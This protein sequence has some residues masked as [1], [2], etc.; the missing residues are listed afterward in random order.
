MSA[1]KRL[2]TTLLAMLLVLQLAAQQGD[3]V[4]CQGFFSPWI[5][6]GWDVK[7]DNWAVWYI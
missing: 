3:V 4:L 6:E 2:V 7:G 5:E 1:M